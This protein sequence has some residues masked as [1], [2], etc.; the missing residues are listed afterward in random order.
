MR[1]TR[2]TVSLNASMEESDK[3]KNNMVIGF[4]N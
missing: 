4:G 3:K 1:R 2:V